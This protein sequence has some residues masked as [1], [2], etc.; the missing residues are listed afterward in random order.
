MKNIL[1][2]DTSTELCSVAL[3]CGAERLSVMDDSGARNTD[4]ILPM[5]DRLLAQA[6]LS[7]RQLDGVT[8]ACG[9]GGFTG[10]RVAAGVAQGIAFGAD[11]PV[12]PLSTLAMLAQAGFEAHAQSLPLQVVVA[13]DARMNE[14]YAA[15]YS[16]SPAMAV[17]QQ[18]QLLKPD[19]LKIEGVLASAHGN[20]NDTHS[21][22]TR[23]LR[24]G[25]AWAAYPTRF[26]LPDDV[27]NSPV[28]ETVVA[29]A[30]YLLS[31][32][33]RFDASLN[34]ATDVYAQFIG[35][36][37]PLWRGVEYAQP[38]YLRNQVA[39]KKAER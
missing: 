35:H 3:Q 39:K 4:V 16:F 15:V 1:A 24:V 9:P 8:F 33:C 32:I 23:L 5:I 17:L 26:E 37:E 18:E 14:V 29:D 22:K 31:L 19:D 34:K 12:A 38:V 27:A 36:N 10:V 11:L 21:T 25:S 30:Q 6:Q 28:D 13:N 20:Q 7:P 2:L